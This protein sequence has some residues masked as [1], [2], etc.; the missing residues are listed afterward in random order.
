MTEETQEF[1]HHT[2]TK[3]FTNE[4]GNTLY[5]RFCR[6]LNFAKQFDCIVGYFRTSGFY[7]LYK[8]L[9]KVEKIRI[10]VGLNVDRLTFDIICQ[11]GQQQEE[12]F[13]NTANINRLFAEEVSKEFEEADDT[14]EVA[15]G[16][17]KFREML[18]GGRIEMRAC[19]DRNTHA[20]VYITRYGENMPLYGSVITGSSNFTENGLKSQYE[21]NVEL[22]DR[23]DVDFALNKFNELWENAVPVSEEYVNAIDNKTWLNQ[24]ITPYQ[25]Y[26]KC[27]YEYFYGRID[28]EEINPYLPEGY[29]AL[30]YQTDAIAEISKTVDEYG[31]IFLS[32]VVGLGKTYIAAM[33][34]QTLKGKILVIAPPPIM[35]NWEN[36]FKDFGLRSRDYDIRS[37]GM[38][39]KIAEEIEKEEN[40]GRKTYDYVFVDEAHRFRNGKSIQYAYLSR[41]CLGKKVVLISA[42]P[43]NNTFFDFYYLL[44]LFQNPLHSDIPGMENYH[45]FFASKR[46]ALK[47]AEKESGSKDSVL[48]LKEIENVSKE[49]RDRILRYVMIRRTRTDI[50]K[51][52][53]DDIK[54]QGLHFPEVQTPEQIIYKFDSQT[55]KVFEKTIS[56]IGGKDTPKEEK[57]LSYARYAPKL[58]ITGRQITDFVKTQQKNNAGFMKSRLVKRLE[59]SKYAFEKTLERSIASHEKIIAMFNSG[60]VYISNDF[61]VLDY[62]EDDEINIEDLMDKG[63]NKNWE[64]IPSFNF[65]S[66]FLPMVKND[67]A[68]LKEI[69]SDWQKIKHDFKQEKFIKEIK[70]NSLLENKKIVVFTESAE[71]GE[72]LA[73][74]LNKIYPGKVLFYSSSKN[75]SIK[76]TIKN[77]Y[78]PNIKDCYKKNDIQILITTDVLAEGINLHRSN[79]IVNYDL[80]WNPTR[81]MQRTGRINRVGTEYDKIYIF[82]FF[83]TSET[84]NVLKLKESIIAKIQAFH[85]ALGEDAKYLSDD[86][87]VESFN[88]SGQR[89]YEALS[90][91]A[92]FD[93]EEE[94]PQLK[95]LKLIK[96]IRKNKPELYVKIADLPKKIRTARHCGNNPQPADKLMTFFRKGKLC[97]F[98][99]TDGAETKNIPFIEAIKYF[100]CE[101]NEPQKNIPQKYY[102]YIVRNKDLFGRPI[103]TEP[104]RQGG[105][106]NKDTVIKTLR[107]LMNVAQ[108]TNEDK[109]YIQSVI[110]ALADMV[111]P[112][113]ISKQLS[114]Y[115]KKTDGNFISILLK[116]QEIVPEPYLNSRQMIKD[117][118]NAKREVVL[119]EFVY[120]QGK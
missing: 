9:D 76:E 70:E 33:Y 29:M 102:E 79:I 19:R 5:E 113:N 4:P 28:L 99:L 7:R 49:L 6:T 84:D 53:S 65:S 72:N 23:P 100:E 48:Y 31:G 35:Q 58:Y 119:S 34:A 32:D 52:F 38:I 67:L 46:M 13:E 56:I 78:D 57:K 92:S 44:N 110:N 83:P 24:S 27:L 87:E 60:T 91:K 68:L 37:I 18:A 97:V 21:F 108:Y 12:L 15:D 1:A 96:E 111:I 50:E 47:K 39:D 73:E 62:V 8:S 81:V 74:A 75:E 71:T 114:D 41:I 82:N 17:S 115:F 43:L 16:V 101:E 55:N 107:S 51:Y 22:K 103:E 118:Q 11:A 10:L 64:A 45:D 116:I 90:S 94:N 80:P 120:S 25:M 59:S 3:F 117:R 42:T 61:D 63:E 69:L 2:D 36:A 14:K 30:K 85:N 98:C 88:L 77:N 112:E 93:D 66:D 89:L 95:Y 104:M 109:L 86:E 26:L 20:K 106:S 105:H 54:T 40:T